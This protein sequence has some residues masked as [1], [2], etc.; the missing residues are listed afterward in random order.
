MRLQR[1]LVRTPI[2][3]ELASN[4]FRCT[5]MYLKNTRITYIL[6]LTDIWLGRRFRAV[7][8]CKYTHGERPW[9]SGL[10]LSTLRT[11][12][13][14]Y[15]LC[16]STSINLQS[17]NAVQVS[18]DYTLKAVMLLRKRRNRALRCLESSSDNRY[19]QVLP[20][21]RLSSSLHCLSNYQTSYCTT[22]RSG[23]AQ[24][25]QPRVLSLFLDPGIPCVVPVM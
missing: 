21:H 12:R 23:S 14:R 6:Q 11:R 16:I 22:T 18:L 5:S 15:E 19:V 9:L 13:A 10:G 25:I 24:E 8:N 17:L 7:W 2:Q 1:G 3:I 4:T 20:V